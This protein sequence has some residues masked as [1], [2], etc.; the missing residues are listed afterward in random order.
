MTIQ[1]VH[2]KIDLH[3]QELNSNVYGNVLPEEKDIFLNEQ[4]LE[5]FRDNEDE[6]SNKLRE[7][8]QATQKRY[9]N[10][11][12]LI[13]E[14][15]LP[16]YVRDSVSMYCTLPEDYLR[17]VSDATILKCSTYKDVNLT[18][19]KEYVYGFELKE[20]VNNAG[21]Y[22][23]GLFIYILAQGTDFALNTFPH[24]TGG[25]KSFKEAFILYDLI[26]E[27][28]N[29]VNRNKDNTKTKYKVY[30]EWYN[31]KYYGTKLLFVSETPM[32][33][34]YSIIAEA[35]VQ[36][37]L[38]E[39]ITAN[40]PDVTTNLEV[41]NRLTATEDVRNVLNSNFRTT[42]H[43]SPISELQQDRLIVHHEKKF[44]PKELKIKYIKR[45]NF[46]SL[47]LNRNTDLNSN[48]LGMIAKRTAER[49]AVVKGNTTSNAIVQHNN[50]IE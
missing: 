44:I 19:K 17:L 22:F 16:L 35:N 20:F 42:V 25:F 43:T 4:I 31:G 18:E 11:K 32:A 40:Q 45:P 30:K 7:N 15:T 39:T 48:V 33:I 14:N 49:I 9:D 34:Y 5:F 50:T 12:E 23:T 46:V 28:L 6:D 1:E 3:L 10:V 37:E 41:E 24:Y 8:F 13:V 36:M 26:Y 21:N 47:Y 29:K 2:V 27:E 38:L